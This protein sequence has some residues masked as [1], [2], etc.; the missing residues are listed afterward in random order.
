MCELDAISSLCSFVGSTDWKVLSELLK[1]LQFVSVIGGIITFI[2]FYRQREIHSR[3]RYTLDVILMHREQSLKHA[4]FQVLQKMNQDE[5]CPSGDRADEDMLGVLNFYEFVCAAFRHG[6]ID[7]K[8]LIDTRAGNITA[9][10]AWARPYVDG[11]RKCTGRETIYEHIEW[12]Y[13]YRTRQLYR[14]GNR[15]TAQ[16]GRRVKWRSWGSVSWW[17]PPWLGGGAGRR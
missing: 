16:L 10:F 6:D 3:K 5:P 7:R 9:V 17:G 13:N 1:T 4:I 15:L 8:L 12:F 11:R 14:E 2:I